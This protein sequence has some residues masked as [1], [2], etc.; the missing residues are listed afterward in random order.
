[1]SAYEIPLTPSSQRFNISLSGVD[2]RLA[3]R[4]NVA[5]DAWLLDVADNDGVPL[6]S[7]VPIVTGVDLLEQYAHLGFGGMLI[8]QS[9]ND[10]VSPPAFDNL[11]TVGRLYWVTS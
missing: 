10:I 4:W 11:G 3:V 1:M 7:G 2:Y 6:V 8:A 9:D 5:A